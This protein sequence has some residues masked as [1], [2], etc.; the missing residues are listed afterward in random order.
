MVREKKSE[1][2]TISKQ[3][4]FERRLILLSDLWDYKKD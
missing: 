3:T 1:F 2:V 4:L